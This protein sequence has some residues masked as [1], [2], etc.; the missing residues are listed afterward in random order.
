[1][2]AV[3]ALID[4]NLPALLLDLL[5]RQGDPVALAARPAP[6]HHKKVDGYPQ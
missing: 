6:P 4:D 2:S 5:S 1:M 3:V